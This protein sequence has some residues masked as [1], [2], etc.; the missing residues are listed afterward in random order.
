MHWI[1]YV[2]VAISVILAVGIGIYFAHRQKDTSTYFAGS[3]KI[4]AWAIGMS[5]FAT[6]ISSVTF[7]AYPGAAYA[8]N[9]NIL[10]A[11]SDFLPVSIVRLPFLWDIFPRWVPYS[12][13]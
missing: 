4:P 3:G 6:L 5:I 12:S 9:W 7:L 8:G 10:N 13:W 1:D 2:I 11:V